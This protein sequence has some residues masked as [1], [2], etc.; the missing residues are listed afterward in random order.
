MLPLERAAK[1]RREADVVLGLINLYD[2]L[3]PYGK[4]FPTGS[5]FLDLMVYPDMDLYITKVNLE[6]LFHIGAQIARCEFVIQVVFEKTDDPVLLPDG[7]YMKPRVKYGD[8]GRPWK[9]DIWSLEEKIIRDKMV[10]M[11]RFQAKL[12]PAL[13]YEILSYKLSVM[14]SEKRT[15]P[16]SGYYIYKAFLDEG[17]SDHAKVTEYL[18]T[19]GIK[20]ESLGSSA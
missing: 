12:T 20:M 19:H 13:R 2:I 7:L 10:E 6:Q 16:Y 4:V 17:L 11:R 5:F 18:I 1:L 8:W 14:T 15:P 3:R 9:I